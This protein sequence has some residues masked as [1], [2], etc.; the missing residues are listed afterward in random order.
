MMETGQVISIYGNFDSEEEFERE[1]AKIY[2]E[3]SKR[4]KKENEEYRRKNLTAKKVYYYE[5]NHH[6]GED[7]ND[8]CYVAVTVKESRAKEMDEHYK[9]ATIDQVMSCIEDLGLE[10]GYVK[11]IEVVEG[12]YGWMEQEFITNLGDEEYFCNYIWMHPSTEFE[13]NSLIKCF[14]RKQ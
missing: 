6:I 13:I 9:L 7:G 11:N 14:G 2:E 3:D 10:G 8:C 12:I 4:I 5:Y 1:V